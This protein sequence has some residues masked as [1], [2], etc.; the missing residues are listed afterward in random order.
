MLDKYVIVK[1]LRL[2]LEDGDKEE[3]DSIG[4]Q[5][6]MLDYYIRQIFKDRNVEIIEIV[7]DGYSGT[8]MD[9]PGI[10]KLLVLA[11]TRQI[12]CIIVKDFSRFARDYIEVGRYLE[13]KFPQWQVRFISVN[14]GYDSN[15]FRGITGGIDM[16]LKSI[17]YTMYSRDLSEKVKSARRVLQKQGK[18]A[19][20]YA[21][22]GYSKSPDDKHKLIID[23]VASEVVKRIFALRLSGT[24]PAQIAYILNED[25]VPTP[26]VYKK[27]NDPMTRNWNTTSNYCKWGSGNV[28]NILRDERYT[29]KMISHKF[30]RIAVGSKK[31]R[32]V[33][34][35][36]RIVVPNT[37]EA[38]ISQE[39]YDAVQALLKRKQCVKKANI[40]LTSLV[41]CGECK[42]K[43]FNSTSGIKGKFFWCDY[44]RYT[45]ENNCFKGRVYE[46]DMI[47]FL[48]KLI[49]T[50][51]EKTVDIAQAQKKADSLM[52]K[53]KKSIQILQRDAD[54][55]KK[56]K[57]T[58]Y[59]KLTKDE[60]TEEEFIKNRVEID[61][62]IEAIN[63]KIQT[64][65]YR[66]ISE[67]D[68]SVLNLFGKYIDTDNIDN[69]VIRDLV[70]AI[71]VY[72]DKRI[73]VVWNFRDTFPT[74]FNRN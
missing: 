11:E 2:S 32:I 8:N 10:K 58:E 61:K 59:I 42:H 17:V 40:S 4:N 16:A 31:E 1:Y 52:Q 60:I 74:D 65:T 48:K 47:D 46:H 9:R 57:L 72:N 66:K 71:Y 34:V 55:E 63:K 27:M 69:D 19:S 39:T 12:N 38:I 3:S 51:L 5:R 28:G 30:E 64:I 20:P 50:E 24:M 49:Q 6:N 56:R 54:S 13:Q 22:Y 53:S 23:P 67:K 73:E 25:R 62:K 36:N 26:S 18:Y 70:K 14:D 43:M 35:E 37:H 21:F 45:A 7:D 41:C 29:G 15:D 33:P 44:K 68:I